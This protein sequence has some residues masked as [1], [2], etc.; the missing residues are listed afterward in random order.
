MTEIVLTFL[1]LQMDF[2]DNGEPARITEKQKTYHAQQ[3][4][5]LQMYPGARLFCEIHGL[6]FFF[7]KITCKIFNDIFP[8]GDVPHLPGK[9]PDLVAACLFILPWF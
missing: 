9:S 5:Y 3:F 4:Q 8:T 6:N 7:L 1:P 2:W